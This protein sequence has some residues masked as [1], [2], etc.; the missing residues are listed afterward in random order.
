M[1]CKI[2]VKFPTG[3]RLAAGSAIL[4]AIFNLSR[5][6]Y[7]KDIR[8]SK[9]LVFYFFLYVYYYNA[10]KKNKHKIH[11][12]TEGGAVMKVVKKIEALLDAYY[13]TFKH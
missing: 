7:E 1:P 5:K 10:R 2:S 9:F 11:H 4:V 8:Y 3:N 6:L 13:E 12:K